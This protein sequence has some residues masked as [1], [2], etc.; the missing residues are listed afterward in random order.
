ML[1]K[2]NK[3]VLY[4]VTKPRG[5]VPDLSL[6]SLYEA[7]STLIR[8]QTKTEQFCSFFNKICVH[9]YRFRPS[10]LQR[11]IAFIPSVR[12]LKWT[13]R[14]RISIYR[15]EKLV[16]NWSHMV[17]SVRHFGYSRSNSLAP[18]RVLMTSPFSDSIVF[19]V[20]T[21]KQHFQKVSFSNRSILESVFEWL[22]FRLSFS[23]L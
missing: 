6:I 3:L 11:R 7:P 14:M 22:G 19:S 18:G 17:A 10:T 12:M 20:H 21:R 13:R 4:V 5:P 16:R 23:A 15:P 1:K 8:F 2:G 9:T